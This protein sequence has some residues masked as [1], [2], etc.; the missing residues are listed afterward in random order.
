MSA[1]LRFFL[2]LK[3][4][5]DNVRRRWP[6]TLLTIRNQTQLKKW[7]VVSHLHPTR[8]SRSIYAEETNSFSQRVSHLLALV[9]TGFATALIRHCPSIPTSV[10]V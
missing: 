6:V 3:W 1:L 2:G 8:Q 7:L 9:G 5:L 10:R 4:A